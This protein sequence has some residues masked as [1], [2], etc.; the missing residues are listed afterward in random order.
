MDTIQGINFNYIILLK[1]LQLYYMERE[2][3][4]DAGVSSVIISYVQHCFKG[5]YV[6]TTQQ[7]FLSFGI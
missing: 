6:V 7:P 2:R 5:M 3:E 1:K 4:R